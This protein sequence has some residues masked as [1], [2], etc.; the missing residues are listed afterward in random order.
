[1]KVLGDSLLIHLLPELAATSPPPHP[2]PAPKKHVVDLSIDRERRVLAEVSRFNDVPMV[3]EGVNEEAEGSGV[4]EAKVSRA[5]E[6]IKR[7]LN[8]V[9]G[10]EAVK[11]G[12]EDGA[13][14]GGVDGDDVRP[15]ES[16]LEVL[17]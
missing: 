2:E 14:R 13:I 10:G 7:V 11:M 15:C 5:P 3:A 17:T 16:E 8:E 6:S 4:I 1:M 12:A 9:C